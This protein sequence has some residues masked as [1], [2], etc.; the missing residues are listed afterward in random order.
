[1]SCRSPQLRQACSVR[2]ITVLC[3]MKETRCQMMTHVTHVTVTTR[4]KFVRRCSVIYLS[5]TWAM[6]SS[7]LQTSAVPAVRKVILPD[8]IITSV[9]GYIMSGVKY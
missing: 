1:M 5:V 3:L 9:Y 8:N 4:R 6:R 7:T 2:T